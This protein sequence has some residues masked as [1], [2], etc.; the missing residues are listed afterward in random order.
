MKTFIRVAGVL[1]VLV[2]FASG[3]TK[4]A[5]GTGGVRTSWTID[6]GVTDAATQSESGLAVNRIYLPRTTPR[7]ALVVFLH[8]SGSLPSAHDTVAAAMRDDGYHVI[9]LRYSAPHDAQSACP[10]STSATYPDC[11]RDF[12]HE[13]V[14]GEGV[15]DPDGISRDH[16]GTSVT[17][18]NSV[19]NR[20][21]KLIEYM[22]VEYP[23]SDLERFQLK[24]EGVCDVENTTYGACDLDWSRVTV[25]GHSHG[26]GVA[27]YMAKHYQLR[28]AG[29]FSGTY[30]AWW[31]G[32]AATAATWTT[33]NDFETPVASIK[34][35]MHESDFGA[36]RI[37]AVSDAVGLSGPEV[38]ATV[39]PFLTNRLITDIASQCP[40]DPA[41]A[42][43]ST[44]MGG[45]VPGTAYHPAWAW[46]AGG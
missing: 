32:A 23:D 11:H 34:T 16:P 9:L 13:T 36:A 44:S 2:L 37:R 19:M 22:N 21:L 12:R 38:S 4:P 39:T 1:A 28:A 17:Q 25:M 42:H 5:S 10:D 46:M 29:L 18:P 6:P 30:D 3:C 14:F 33:E 26:S 15:A 7:D 24:T 31:D 41:A 35:L 8:G 45:C 43:N 20:L 40:W 27:L